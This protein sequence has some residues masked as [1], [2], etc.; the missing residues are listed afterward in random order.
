MTEMMKATYE[1]LFRIV[2]QRKVKALSER[3]NPKY[4]TTSIRLLSYNAI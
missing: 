2:K 1:F 4:C 3:K